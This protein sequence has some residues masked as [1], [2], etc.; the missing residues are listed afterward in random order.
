MVYEQHQNPQD[1]I[2]A[3]IFNHKSYF[4]MFN[5]TIHFNS[6]SSTDL[7]KLELVTTSEL[8]YNVH[9]SQSQLLLFFQK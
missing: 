2:T 3:L 8:D 9:L 6:C 5:K 7:A 1:Q 4:V